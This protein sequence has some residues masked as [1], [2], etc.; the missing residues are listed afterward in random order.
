MQISKMDRK[1]DKMFLVFKIIAFD[2][3]TAD[4][5]YYKDITCHRQSMF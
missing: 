1:I 3:V 2:I 4:S 5:K